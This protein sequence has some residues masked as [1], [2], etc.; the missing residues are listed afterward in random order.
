M[1]SLMPFGDLAK[2]MEIK[3]SKCNVYETTGDSNCLIYTASVTEMF[4]GFPH[5]EYNIDDLA[6]KLMN[7]GY[8]DSI[9][10][11]RKGYEKYLVIFFNPDFKDYQLK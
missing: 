6:L 7:M 1:S 4:E 9:A 8:V 3:L 10:S 5:P 2:D 11:K